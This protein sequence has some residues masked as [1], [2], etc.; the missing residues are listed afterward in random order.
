MDTLLSDIQRS[1]LPARA[2]AAYVCAVNKL[3]HSAVYNAPY[4]VYYT[5]T[6]KGH[7]PMTISLDQLK[8]IHPGG[9]YCEEHGCFYFMDYDGQL[10]YFIEYE[11]AFEEEANWVDFDTLSED[12]VYEIREFAANIAYNS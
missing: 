4:A 11:G 1:I 12:E 5:H 8:N 3:T 2:H 7:Q 9:E 6:H 10:G